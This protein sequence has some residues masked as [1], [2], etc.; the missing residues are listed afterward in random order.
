[1]HRNT[2]LSI[3]GRRLVPRY[4]SRPIAHVAAETRISHACP[5]EVGQWAS[6]AL[7]ARSARPLVNTS[8]SAGARSRHLLSLG[9]NRR[10]FIDP[11][12]DSNREPRRLVAQRR[13]HTVHID[14]KKVGR[15]SD[16]GGW[17]VHG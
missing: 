11:N 2:P 6:P 13:G 10:R 7:A 14:V 4:G 8:S 3:E 12:G 17:R 16:G 15:I 5:F 1:M 9:L